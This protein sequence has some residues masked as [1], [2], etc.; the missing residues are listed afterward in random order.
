MFQGKFT[1]TYLCKICNTHSTL[2]LITEQRPDAGGDALRKHNSPLP[3]D[4]RR[5]QAAFLMLTISF[6]PPSWIDLSYCFRSHLPSRRPSRS[7]RSTTGL[8]DL[9]LPDRVPCLAPDPGPS[10]S[11]SPMLLVSP[12][13]FVLPSAF[14]SYPSLPRSRDCSIIGRLPGNDGLDAPTTVD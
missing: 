12:P 4:Y 5:P 9:L 1:R 6:G 11:G 7:L 10:N 8:D 2:E 14:S 13:E 3:E